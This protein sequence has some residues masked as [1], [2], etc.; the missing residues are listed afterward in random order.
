MAEQDS[1]LFDH[2]F[3]IET[4]NYKKYVKVA[5]IEAVSNT[6]T[7]EIKL[8]LDVNVE[9]W[10]LNEGDLVQVA[11]ATSLSLTGAKDDGKAW[12]HVGLGEST[13]ADDYDYVCHGK[14]YRFEEGTG[15]NM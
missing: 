9:L 8:M 1:V 11:L 13:I 14:I 3:R 12:R 7:Q 4:I 5:R 10:P 6:D 15:D 2:P